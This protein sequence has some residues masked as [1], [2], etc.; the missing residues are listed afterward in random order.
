M[1]KIENIKKLA[2]ALRDCGYEVE[3]N[4]GCL[5][6]CIDGKIHTGIELEIPDTCD[7]DGYSYS[8]IFDNHGNRINDCT[9][10][11]II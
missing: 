9:E 6:D 2:K 7:G 10:G 11:E 3:L 1:G 8:F 4:F 5:W